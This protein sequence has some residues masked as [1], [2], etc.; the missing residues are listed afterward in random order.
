M[1]QFCYM[2]DD[3]DEISFLDSACLAYTSTSV[4]ILLYVKVMQWKQFGCQVPSAWC[5]TGKRHNF[6]W[7]SCKMYLKFVSVYTVYITYTS[8]GDHSSSLL[9]VY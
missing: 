5:H 7:R 8:L 6:E 3:L 4:N 1:N 9:T 2:N